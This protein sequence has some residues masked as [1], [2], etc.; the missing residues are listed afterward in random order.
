MKP[1]VCVL[2]FSGVAVFTAATLFFA[3][4]PDGFIYHND[5][6]LQFCSA[7]LSYQCHFS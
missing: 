4:Y 5:A 1:A 3:V 6:I 7:G 2:Q